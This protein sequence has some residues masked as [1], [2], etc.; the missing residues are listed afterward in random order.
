V[1]NNQSALAMSRFR[2]RTDADSSPIGD[3]SCLLDDVFRPCHFY[4]GT[5]LAANWRSA[6][7]E[8]ISWEIFQGRLLDAAQTRERRSFRSWNLFEQ[9]PEGPAPLPLISLKWDAPAQAI[10]VVR[11]LLCH[12]WESY[13]AG[14]D[15]IESRETTKWVLEL[16]GTVL[17]ADCADAEE[18]RDELI[19]RLWQAVVGTSRLPLSSLEAPLPGFALGQLAYVYRPGAKDDEP[20]RDWRNLCEDVWLTDL[21]RREQ[22]KFLEVV[23]RAATPEEIPDAAARFVHK[24]IDPLGLL[25]AVFNDVSLSPWTG[26]AEN[27]LA[28]VQAL[29]Q[30]EGVFYL[31]EFA[32]LGSLLLKL[33]RHLTAYDLVTFHHRGANY[34]DALLLDAALKRLLRLAEVKPTLFSEETD[35]WSGARMRGALRHAVVLRRGY[36]N[37]AVPDAPTSPGENARL[38]PAPFRR[39]PFAQLDNPLRRQR[40]LFAGDSLAKL[41]TTTTKR[42][43]QLSLEDL[44][45]FACRVDLGKAIFIDRPLG[46]GKAPLEPDQ[47]PLIAHE[48]YSHAIACRRIDA[49]AELAREMG[50]ALPADWHQWRAMLDQDPS[51]VIGTPI[52]HCTSLGRPVAALADAQRVS[53]DFVIVRTMPGS[54]QRLRELFDWG[55]LN[56]RFQLNNLWLS[57]QLQYLRVPSGNHGSVMAICDGCIW[58]YRQAD[59]ARRVL[60]ESD[61]AHGY[62]SRDGVELPR[63]GLCIWMVR[64]DN[65][66]EYDLRG[67]EFHVPPR[68]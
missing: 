45:D 2:F 22:V 7:A 52:A 54:V 34:P 1:N 68:F 58:K 14:G 32:F 66:Q 38:L 61:P 47:T 8:T 49:L 31:E 57:P 64:D 4:L 33:S 19:C 25:R 62:R 18:L 41:W 27:A 43:V 67:E 12:V 17:L 15:V 26:F 51:A 48:A 59:L 16:V 29:V 55:V 65:D 20:I 37:H 30:Q 24:P 53:E 36:E 3:P 60:F 40:R 44:A 10:H 9:T 6:V 13:D 23:L 46:F 5:G 50:V 56:R 35:S 63:A 21:S 39:V 11:G 28:F 42:I